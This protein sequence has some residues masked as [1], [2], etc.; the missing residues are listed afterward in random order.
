MPKQFLYV[1]DAISYTLSKSPQ[2][3]VEA[4][5][6]MYLSFVK[7]TFKN[8]LERFNLESLLMQKDDYDFMC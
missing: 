1:L 2:T 4:S 3:H 7:R 5:R 6:S 8:E